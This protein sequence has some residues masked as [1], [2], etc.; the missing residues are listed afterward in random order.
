MVDIHALKS[1]LTSHFTGGIMDEEKALRAAICLPL[2]K[3]ENDWHLLFE[4]RA[5]HL[6]SQPGD[7]CFPGGKIDPDDSTPLH[8]AVRETSEELG[9]LK[10]SIEIIGALDRYVPSSQFIIYPFVGLLKDLHFNINKEEVDHTFTIPL[11]WLLSHQ[12]EKHRVNM[13]PKPGED[14]P[15]ERIAQGRDY[16]WRRRTMVELFYH[17]EDHSVWGMT[18]KILTHFLEVIKKEHIL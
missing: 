12:P 17:Y 7:I 2:F 5:F 14:F 18:A 15:Y 3:L 9:I 1:A 8:T 13:D 4:V 10:E 11:K 6:K 16:K